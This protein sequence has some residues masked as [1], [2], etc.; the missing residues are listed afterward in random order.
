MGYTT[1]GFG[2]FK[3]VWWVLRPGEEPP[4]LDEITKAAQKEFANVPSHQL[5]VYSSIVLS[6][7][8]DYPIIKMRIKNT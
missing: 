3:E 1:I 8:Y 2:E 4:T 5:I 6:S 7:P